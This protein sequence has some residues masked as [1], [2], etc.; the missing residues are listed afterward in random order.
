MIERRPWLFASLLV[1]LSWWAF[2][3]SDHVPGLFKIAW[4]ATPL[5]LLAIYSFQRHLGP[6]GT[7]LAG[8]MGMAALADG[9]SELVYSA[10]GTL[11]GFSLLLAIWLYS[12]NRREHLALSQKGVALALV[13]A[14]PAISWFLVPQEDGRTLVAGY[15]L[16]MA[17]M[18]A[19]AWTS[20]FSRYRV[21]MGA[22]MFVVSE[23]LLF[24]VSGPML[25]GN[26]WAAWLIYPIYYSGQLLIATG[27]VSRLR[28]EAAA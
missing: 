27:V 22:M 15:A 20:R 28:R 21:G 9:I 26:A 25:R 11:M 6:D 1:A 16:L 18:A 3:D 12:R 19:M 10:A 14:L 23:L 2:G 13:I 5:S 24:A 7:I 17:I 8:V 4:K